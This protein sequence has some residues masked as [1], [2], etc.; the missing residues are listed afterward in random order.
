VFLYAWAVS[1]RETGWAGYA[2]SLVFISVLAAALVYLWRLG[3]LDW[4]KRRPMRDS[5]A[6]TFMDRRAQGEGKRT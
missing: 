6:G 3:A 2:E 1:V 5:L 4:G